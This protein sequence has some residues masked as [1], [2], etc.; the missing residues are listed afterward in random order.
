[1]CEREGMRCMPLLN[2]AHMCYHENS[3]V[4]WFKHHPT[5]GVCGQQM[6]ETC[7][8]SHRPFFAT[9]TLDALYRWLL[10]VAVLLLSVLFAYVICPGVCL[11]GWV[12]CFLTGTTW[13][14]HFVVTFRFSFMCIDFN[15]H[16]MLHPCT[17][18]KRST[19]PKVGNICFTLERKSNICHWHDCREHFKINVTIEFT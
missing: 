14:H 17:N 4:T 11:S 7:K 5:R 1:M 9:E 12:N 8:R 18:I 19:A 13:C 15:P 3:V 16:Q 10:L 2:I 6:D